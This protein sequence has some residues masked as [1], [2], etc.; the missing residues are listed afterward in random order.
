M[1]HPGGEPLEQVCLVAGDAEVPQL[2]LRVRVG[3]GEGASGGAGVVV[4][5]GQ[6]QRRL[7]VGRDPGRER[8]A[9]E[10]A[11]GQAY[12]L[13]Q[14]DDRIQHRADG[15]GQRAAVE[16]DRVL[17]R[18]SAAEEPGAVALP[19]HGPLHAPFHA[20]HVHGKQARFL[21]RPR[22]AAAEE[23]RAVGDVLGL[24]EQLAE[25]GVGE[26]V[27]REAEDRLGV[28]RDLDLPG[29]VA[30]VGEGE[31]PHLHVVLR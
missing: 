9:Y 4:L 27:G 6:H 12:A 22:P 18:A 14:A 16:G 21:R 8:H 1:E 24:Q 11:G 5:L 26:I 3:E 13:A 10:A 29:P 20:Q 7:A 15:A 30:A 23:S 19:L 25:G 31:S 28:A 2:D 17:R